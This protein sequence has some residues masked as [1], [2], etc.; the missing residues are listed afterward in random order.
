[1]EHIIEKDGRYYDLLRPSIQPNGFSSQE[2]AEAM[3]DGH[4]AQVAKMFKQTDVFVFTF[5]LTEGWVDRRD[6]TVYPVC[7]GTVVGDFDPDKYEFKNFDY[8]EIK[9]DMDDFITKARTINPKMRFIF[10]VSSVPLVA[11]ASHQHVLPATVYSKSVLRAVAGDLEKNDAGIDYFPSYEVVSGIQARSVFYNMD[12][13]T[14]H[15]RGVDTVMEHFFRQHPPFGEVQQTEPKRQDEEKDPVC[16]EM[17]LDA[18]S[19]EK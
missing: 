18:D 13:R 6:G 15:L 8:S 1:M 16:D 10:T 14:I 12:L 2:E 5:G 17:V 3:C 11:T 9:Q 4:L 7:P 19:K